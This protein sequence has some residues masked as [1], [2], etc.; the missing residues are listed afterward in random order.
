MMSLVIECGLPGRHRETV[1]VLA[2]EGKHYE[3]N[4]LL[5][6]MAEP[7]SGRLSNNLGDM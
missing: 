3:I 7:T 6:V 4:G 1:T 2:A 5:T